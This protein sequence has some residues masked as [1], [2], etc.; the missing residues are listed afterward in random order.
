MQQSTNTPTRAAV[1]AALNTIMDTIQEGVEA[2]PHG[3]PEGH[4]YA[5]LMQHMTLEQFN[6][7]ISVM[8]ERGKIRKSGH[9]LLPSKL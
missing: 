3:M 8:V 9:L 2:M 5:T 4:L 7:I 1:L 6:T